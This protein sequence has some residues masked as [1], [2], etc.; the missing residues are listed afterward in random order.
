[1]RQFVEGIAPLVG[2]VAGV[3]C[4]P[5]HREHRELDAGGCQD[6]R[7]DVGDALDIG[8]ARFD[9]DQRLERI[10]QGLLLARAPRPPAGNH[11]RQP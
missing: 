7:T 9:L 3:R 4:A 8:A 6:E 11:A 5:G 2:R 1:M 10:Q